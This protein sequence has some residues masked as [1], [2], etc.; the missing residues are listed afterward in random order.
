[1][2]TIDT[3]TAEEIKAELEGCQPVEVEEVVE[4]KEGE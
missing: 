1:M 2:A 3:R 4:V